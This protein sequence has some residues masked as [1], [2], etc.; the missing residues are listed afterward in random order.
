MTVSFVTSTFGGRT[1]LWAGAPHMSDVLLD[2]DSDERTVFGPGAVVV[3][4][5]LVAKQLVQ[6][7]PGMAGPLADTAVRDRVLPVVEA[8]GAIERTQLVVRLERPVFVS[9]LAPRDVDGSRDVPGPLGLLLREMSRSQEPAGELVRGPHIDQILDADCVDRLVAE[10]TDRGVL[11]GRGV[12]G[13]RPSVE[14]PL[15]ATAVEQ[16]HV[17]VPLQLEI[18]VRV[19]REPVVVAAIKHHGVVVADTAFA[20]QLLE[21]FLADEV[22]ANLVL[23]VGLPVQL[24]RTGDVTTVIC[25]S[26]FVDLDEDHS[27]GG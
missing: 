25:R 2:R 20:E 19:R 22:P 18:P 17:L 15:L 5:V 26:V 1:G 14:L 23:Q 16:L 10:R 11:I 27:G 7:E 6:G 8:G 3:L 9:R 13:R 12:R 21:L 4:D 24:H